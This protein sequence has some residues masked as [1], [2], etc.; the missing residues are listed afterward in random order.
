MTF[1][2]ALGPTIR[3]CFPV[4]TVAPRRR[5][6]KS[7]RAWR[8]RRH[9]TVSAG[10]LQEGGDRTVAAAPEKIL[11]PGGL[12][13]IDVIV[14][15]LTTGDYTLELYGNARELLPNPI[16]FSAVI[17]PRWHFRPSDATLFD[18]TFGKKTG[19]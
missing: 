6:E 16:K 5:W 10:G 3:S 12:L 13:L 14:P 17:P 1:A 8:W 11:N 2:P 4:P 7:L 18:P 9:F 19:Q 15:D